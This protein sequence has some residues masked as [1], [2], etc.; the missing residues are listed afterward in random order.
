MSRIPA[1][2]GTRRRV[3]LALTVLWALMAV[4]TLLFWSHSLPWTNFMS[5]YANVAGHW[6]ALEGAKAAENSE[7][8]RKRL[9]GQPAMLASRRIRA[10]RAA[11]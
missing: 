2:A 9:R 5:L 7:S 10:A 4:P 8:A 1:G 3:H 6:S 11:R